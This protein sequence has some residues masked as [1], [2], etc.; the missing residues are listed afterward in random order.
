[1]NR[2]IVAVVAA[3]LAL[4]GCGDDKPAYEPLPWQVPG[5]AGKDGVDGVDGEPGPVGA[6][7]KDAA[8]SGSRLKARM[9][10]GED[11]SR[12]FAGSWTDTARDDEAC[13]FQN[14]ATKDVPS[15]EVRCLPDFAIVG[16]ISTFTSSACTGEYALGPTYAGSGKP[17]L[18]IIGTGKI[19]HAGEA[20]AQGYWM[21]DAT[22]QCEPAPGESEWHAW[23]EVPA[24]AFVKGT[25]D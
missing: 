17:Y 8:L 21:N 15:D 7:G 18:R 3:G 24:T 14:I 16:V 12:M 6:P 10:V 22:S 11:G 19:Y 25:T 4:A 23:P 2:S 9:L 20:V 1:M 13:T 5:P